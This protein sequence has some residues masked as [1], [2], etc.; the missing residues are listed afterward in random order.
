M[1]NEAHTAP[2]PISLITEMAKKPEAASSLL[3]TTV[4]A[5]TPFLNGKNKG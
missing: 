2:N 3:L 1:S 4:I 5:K